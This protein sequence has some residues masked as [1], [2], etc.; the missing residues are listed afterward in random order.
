MPYVAVICNDYVVTAEWLLQGVSAVG[1]PPTGNKFAVMCKAG[2][3]YKARADP[4]LQQLFTEGN[5]RESRAGHNNNA[6][7]ADVII[8]DAVVVY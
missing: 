2:G 6:E 8:N 1:K 3:E 7:K 5:K 4:F